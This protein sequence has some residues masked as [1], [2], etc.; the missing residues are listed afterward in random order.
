[1]AGQEK[2]F[3]KSFIKACVGVVN[4]N[5]NEYIDTTGLECKTLDGSIQNVNVID[6]S[7][8]MINKPRKECK[9]HSNTIQYGV[10]K[11]HN[12]T[13]QQTKTIRMLIIN[14]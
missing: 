6:E 8:V 11:E 3:L 2:G 12:Q 5:D 9:Q 1:M 7:S 13:R 4:C 10:S 14:K